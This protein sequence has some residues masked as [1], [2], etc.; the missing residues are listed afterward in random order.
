MK[1]KSIHSQVI[2]CRVC[3][4]RNP[5]VYVNR[6]SLWSARELVERNTYLVRLKSTGGRGGFSDRPQERRT[7]LNRAQRV[8]LGRP[9]NMNWRKSCA[10]RTDARF[11]PIGEIGFSL[12]L[13]A[14]EPCC[15][16]GTVSPRLCSS[17]IFGIA[18]S[19]P[20][21]AQTAIRHKKKH[22]TRRWAAK[23]VNDLIPTPMD[24]RFSPFSVFLQNP[25]AAPRSVQVCDK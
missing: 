2:S 21:Y 25:F 17:H 1:W 8:V 13:W 10:R 15:R 18:F 24:A 20:L 4:G 23:N 22:R 6:V 7:E 5:S 19:R 9:A 3:T 11:M 16:V 14:G 12:K